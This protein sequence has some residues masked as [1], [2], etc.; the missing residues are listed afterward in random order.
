M[1]FI[2]LRKLIQVFVI[3]QREVEVPPRQ[4]KHQG[5]VG[6]KQ[7][8]VSKILY[9]GSEYIFIYILGVHQILCFF[10]KNS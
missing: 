6:G 8:C 4:D 2:S 10:S 1:K 9:Q 3:V 7:Y 5:E